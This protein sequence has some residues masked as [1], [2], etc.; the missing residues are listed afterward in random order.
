MRIFEHPNDYWMAALGGF[1]ILA[2]NFF[3][4]R[5]PA[6]DPLTKFHRAFVPTVA[7]LVCGWGVWHLLN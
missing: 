4:F 3:S 5:S 1:V 7:A 6:T 2:A